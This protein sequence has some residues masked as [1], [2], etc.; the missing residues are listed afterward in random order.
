MNRI[1]GSPSLNDNSA[2]AM[3]V[4]YE[5]WRANFVRPMLL[6]A[7]ILGLLALIPALVSAQSFVLDVI[8]ISVYVV[9][10]IVTVFE[11]PY[12]LRMGLFLFLIYVLGVTE[13]FSTGILG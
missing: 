10:A 5:N 1:S 11:F 6:A 13:I 4:V 7:V 3:D 8:F 9:L 12:W 2:A